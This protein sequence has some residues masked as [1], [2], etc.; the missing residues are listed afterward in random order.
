MEKDN[1][2]K[3]SVPNKYEEL[4]LDEI[5]EGNSVYMKND[6]LNI[7]KDE[8]DFIIHSQ[9]ELSEKRNNEIKNKINSDNKEIIEDINK[10]S[11]KQVFTYP[12]IMDSKV[13]EKE[14][15]KNNEKKEEKKV[16]KLEEEEK[17]EEKIGKNEK[18]EKHEKVINTEK[19]N[20]KNNSKEELIQQ[21]DIQEKSQETSNEIIPK[22]NNIIKENE[23][24][25]DIPQK[26]ESDNIIHYPLI[27][28]PYN[29]QINNNDFVEVQ[30]DKEDMGNNY[31]NNNQNIEF[32]EKPSEFE[33]NKNEN[34]NNGRG[35]GE[36]V[37]VLFELILK[38]DLNSL[39]NESYYLVKEKEDVDDFIGSHKMYEIIYMSIGQEKEIKCYRRYDN[40]SQLHKKL[41]YKYPYIVIPNLPP[42]SPLNKIIQLDKSFYEKRRL[43]L[44]FYLNF[45]SRHPFL[46]ETKE[47]TKF[48]TD[49]NFDSQFFQRTSNDNPLPSFTSSPSDMLRNK[50]YSVLNFMGTGGKVREINNDEVTIKN[51]TIHYKNILGKYQDMRTSICEYLNTIEIEGD[52][53]N[54]FSEVLVYLKD[55]F[56]NDENSKD[57]LLDYSDYCKKISKSNTNSLSNI[58]QLENKLDSLIFLLSGIC[59]SL[60]S[61]C[62]FIK[63]F[64]N[65]NKMKNSAKEGNWEN[66]NSIT[67][68]YDACINLKNI[69][70]QSLTQETSYYVT[71]FE[72]ITSKILKEFHALLFIINDGMVCANTITNN[73]IFPTNDNDN[74]IRSN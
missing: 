20:T 70:D 44:T 17:N 73:N 13:E 62:N 34:G 10:F 64:E 30:I 72:K 58:K 16:I 40:F 12:P 54:K 6:E 47:F 31:K 9:E 1:K 27:D 14:K 68:E 45:L 11:N 49:P 21:I 55:S 2:N 56:I 5:P 38:N 52:E 41:Q 33:V 59:N 63:R 32:I 29:N 15:K 46:K 25:E 60:E 8:K 4:L 42:K 28:E 7:D 37:I 61:Y 67:I 50:L 39:N 57:K 48:I 74:L 24:K 18:S 66:I 71:V 35:E 65:V 19:Q 51:M 22:E 69:W 3:N 26:T 23:K 53:Y 43:Q 36:S